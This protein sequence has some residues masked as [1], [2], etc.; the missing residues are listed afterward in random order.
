MA[1][2]VPATQPSHRLR[3]AYGVHLPHRPP[4]PRH[5]QQNRASHPLPTPETKPAVSPAQAGEEG[6][7]ALYHLF[8][9]V[10]HVGSGPSMGH[11]VCMVKSHDHWLLFDDDIVEVRVRAA[12]RVRRGPRDSRLAQP[13]ACSLPA[14]PREVPRC[15]VTHKLGR[16]EVRDNSKK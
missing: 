10:I 9:V 5:S 13:A 1:P 11:Y 6:A 15:T 4:L 12:V 7:D 16:L 3:R 8:A 2:P 14:G